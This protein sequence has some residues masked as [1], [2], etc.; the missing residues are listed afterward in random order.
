MFSLSVIVPDDIDESDDEIIQEELK[1]STPYVVKQHK[2]STP[3]VVKQHKKRSIL[4][5]FLIKMGRLEH[6]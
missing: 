3:Y 4:K 1:K 2:K 6:L 5:K